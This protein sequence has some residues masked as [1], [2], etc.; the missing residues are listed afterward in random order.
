MNGKG[1]LVTV[2][3]VVVTLLVTTGVT[4]AA[5]ETSRERIVQEKRQ[6]EARAYFEKGRAL[7]DAGRTEEARLPLKLSGCLPGCER[8]WVTSPPTS[9]CWRPRCATSRWPGGP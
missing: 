8:N 7:M 2:A 1:L 3:I 6:A 5:E 4:G 9:S